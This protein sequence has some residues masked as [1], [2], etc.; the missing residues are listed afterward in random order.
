MPFFHKLV[1]NDDIITIVSEE[2][3]VV[4]GFLI[5]SIMDA[6]PVYDPGGKVCMIDDY[7][8]GEPTLWESAGFS[9]LERC[10][11]LAKDRG[12]VLQIIVCGQRDLAKS[13]MLKNAHAEVT[14]EWY[15][16]PV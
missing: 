1:E 14:S 3:G 16:R 10:G 9:L 15:V 13:R 5:G 4:N 8:V 7:M 2:D 11:E 12:C 6:P